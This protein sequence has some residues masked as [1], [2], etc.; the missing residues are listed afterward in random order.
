M[1]RSLL[2]IY[3]TVSSGIVILISDVMTFKARFKIKAQILFSEKTFFP[4]S[5]CCSLVVSVRYSYANIKTTS[6][7]WIGIKH[8]QYAANILPDC[9]GPL[10]F[11]T[12]YIL[13]PYR[14]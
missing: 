3:F 6:R 1:I 12:L 9:S 5:H 7:E 11:T 13:P 10:T 2:Q 8:L 14:V 4:L